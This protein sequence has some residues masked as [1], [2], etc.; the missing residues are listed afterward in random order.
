MG[1]VT[2]LSQVTDPSTASFA[3]PSFDGFT[4]VAEATIPKNSR[5]GRDAVV[6]CS[7]FVMVFEIPDMRRKQLS[8]L[9]RLIRDSEGHLADLAREAARR[10]AQTHGLL[11]VL[12]AELREHVQHLH[13][14]VE[15][16]ATVT[17]DSPAWAS[18]LRYEPELVLAALAEASVAA[19]TLRVKVRPR[20]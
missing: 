4:I 10:S 5:L 9:N 12:P 1:S 11:P 20:Q 7:G 2:P 8:S 19:N 15:G 14:S 18:R 13:V 17:L 6:V 3:L 16:T